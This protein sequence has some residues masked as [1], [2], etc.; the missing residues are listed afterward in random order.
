MNPSRHP[1]AD[2]E[3]RLVS[4]IFLDDG[5]TLADACAR[6]IAPDFFTHPAARAVFE[7]VLELRRNRRPVTV[8]GVL[9]LLADT[10]RLDAIGGVPA[11]SEITGSAPTSLQ[12][13]ADV[14]RIATCHALRT[15]AA[16]ARKAAEIAESPDAGD[17]AT[18]FDEMLPHL[19]AAQE[20]G[21]PV[22]VRN[23]AA[24]ADAAA[25]GLESDGA[26]GVPGPFPGWDRIAGALAPGELAVLAARPGH[27]KTALALQHASA[28]CRAG[29]RCVVFSLEMTGE[30]L[31]GRLARQALGA[32]AGR[33]ELASWIRTD[34][35]NTK[36][37][38][39]YDGASGATLGQIEARSRLHAAHPT[40]VGLI[41]VDY[42]Q[43][44]A[45][46]PDTRR[47][48][49]ERQVATISRALKI[50]AGELRVPVLL[51]A[52]LNRESERE[53]RRPRLTDLRESGAIEQDADAVW[54]LHPD[55]SGPQQSDADRVPVHL[56]QA[57]RRGGPAGIS[58]P[59]MFQR[60]AV[61]FSPATSESKA[62]FHQ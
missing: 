12:A 29:R 1:T 25:A 4:A 37:L 34:L 48:N 45:P 41:V 8:D 14:E 3:A 5:E 11:I 52:Q 26:R 61:T 33:R 53:E 23:L 44:I 15:A 24:V 50:L 21:A 6:G 47:D 19:R 2:H 22:V 10:G 36:H 32:T 31:C 59:L 9:D 40:G 62:A 20:A 7:T 13:A 17:F 55:T 46:P 51:L 56:I 30:E 58:A 43:L 42:L 54:F 38:A 39:I 18:R 28:C 49:R 60:P 16:H 57:K 35:R 27:G